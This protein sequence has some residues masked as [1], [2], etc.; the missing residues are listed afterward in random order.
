MEDDREF[1]EVERQVKEMVEINRV[2]EMYIG[3]E[4]EV[5]EGEVEQERKEGERKGR[6][7]RKYCGCD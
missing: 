3:K 1:C 7:G 2:G 4:E 6:G 5:I